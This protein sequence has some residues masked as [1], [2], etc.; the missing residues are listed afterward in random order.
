MKKPTILLMSLCLLALLS[1]GAY[2]A[3]N[4]PAPK[5]TE[6][7][8]GDWTTL[9]KR[10]PM[11][12]LAAEDEVPEAPSP[13]ILANWWNA[14]GDETLTRLIQYSLE[15]NR[16][17]ISARAKFR[18]ARAALGISKSAVLPWLDNSN[19]LTRSKTGKSGSSTGSQIGPM[20][21]YSLG[22]DA[23]WEIDIFGG[24]AQKIKAGKADL[25]AEFGALHNA[26][27]TLS[28]EVALNYT[29]LRTLQ[30]RLQVAESNLALQMD[31]VELLQSQH[32]SGLKDG[33]ALNQAKYTMEQTRS[34]IP[35][36]RTSIEETMNRLAILVG[37]VPGSLEEMLGEY[38]PLPE[39]EAVGLVGIPA[40]SLRQRPDIYSAERRLAAQ[41][42]RKKSAQ[43][44]LW[45]KFN[46]FGSIGLESFTT[47]GLSLSDGI[48]YGFGPSISWP[49]F[50]G[51]A[52]R[53]NIKIQTAKQE[54]LLAA[55]EQTVL[56]AVAEVRNALTSETQE[57]ERNQSL[58]RGVDAA[59]TAFE[60]AEDKYKNGLTDFNNVI[61]AQSALLTL[62]E[63]YAISEGQMLSNIVRIFKVLGGGWAPLA[64]GGFPQP[65]DGDT[66]K[67]TESQISSE[68]RS[69]LEQIRQE[70]K[71]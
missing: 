39:P 14:L 18:E 67:T 24:Q 4:A 15:N 12:Y 35:P 52:I 42:A 48:S 45:P 62:E 36:L 28:S 65:V 51:G 10:Y 37:Q 70:L 59:R 21:F 31:T 63:Q 41:I 7:E 57:R 38:R 19:T 5:D 2:G 61:G 71:D 47:G 34:T 54:Q 17:L 1:F 3:D 16:D 66:A 53:S 44:D 33:L 11:S 60:I 58:R 23:S 69:Y 43:R 50:H 6:L 56:N 13:E 8:T 49:I 9:A 26:W 64:A 29:S 40:N 46:L 30:K 22:V 20:D 25:Q 68:S 55:Y 32:D 27:V